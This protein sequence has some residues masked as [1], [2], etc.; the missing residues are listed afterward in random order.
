MSPIKGCKTIVD[1]VCR[2]CSQYSDI[3][4]TDE[5]RTQGCCEA[6]MPATVAC[7]NLTT[8]QTHKLYTG[9]IL[10][11]AP[12]SNENVK[13]LCVHH[14]VRRLW[15]IMRSEV[16]LTEDHQ[17][18]PDTSQYKIL[19]YLFGLGCQKWMSQIG[20][21]VG[22]LGSKIVLNDTSNPFPLHFNTHHTPN[23][24]HLAQHGK[25]I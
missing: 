2:K 19:L 13:R 24:H 1:S 15:R 11:Q 3:A 14:V 20:D 10:S 17:R 4:R 21:L 23:L 16:T 5:T 7:R 18:F 8:R 22:A 9:Q 25:Q 12:K 6:P